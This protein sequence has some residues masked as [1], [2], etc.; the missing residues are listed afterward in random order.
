MLKCKI[1]SNFTATIAI[2]EHCNKLSVICSPG[3][4]VD[5]DCALYIG[6]Q[7]TD[8]VQGYFKGYIDDVS[9]CN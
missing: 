8:N 3:S 2:R 5:T 7:G 1:L 4:I 6:F 9:I